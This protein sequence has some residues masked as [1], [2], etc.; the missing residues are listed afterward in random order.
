METEIYKGIEIKIQTD[1]C[2]LN[3]RTDWDNAG[4]MFCK[5]RRYDLGDSNH[6]IDDS[7]CQSWEDVKDLIIKEKKPLVI[8]PLYLYDHSGITMN[9][10]GFSCRWDSGQV[11]WIYLTKKGCKEMGWTKPYINSLSKGANDKYCGKLFEE[12]LEMF[13]VGEVESYDDY[14]SGNVYGYV[15]ESD[16]VED[17]CFGFFG[18]DHEKSGLLLEARANI[19]AALSSSTKS[20]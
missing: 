5:H 12:I 10:T 8:L 7:D 11:G 14:I 16:L 6:G 18:D 9:T 17:S 2:P 20:A 3:P 19:D 1:D 13:L 15:I 4:V